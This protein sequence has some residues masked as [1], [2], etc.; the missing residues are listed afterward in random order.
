MSAEN[1]ASIED[2]DFRWEKSNRTVGET[3]MVTLITD[4]GL[5]HG[6][7][8]WERAEKA[9]DNLRREDLVDSYGTFWDSTGGEGIVQFKTTSFGVDLFAAALG[10]EIIGFGDLCQCDLDL[11]QLDPVI[12]PMATESAAQFHDVYSTG[13]YDDA[14]TR[15]IE[16]RQAEV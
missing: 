10:I 11:L 4:P 14:W 6:D 9:L 3:E 12:P 16:A 13:D 5:P 2:T 1:F 8:D 15:M 7:P